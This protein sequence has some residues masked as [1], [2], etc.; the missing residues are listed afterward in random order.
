MPPQTDISDSQ[1]A[2]S[3]REETQN[4][5]I[6]VMAF[7]ILIIVFIVMFISDSAYLQTVMNHYVV[8]GLLIAYSLTKAITLPCYKYWYPIALLGGLFIGG[9]LISSLTISTARMGAILLA[10]VFIAD[11]LYTGW[12]YKN[13]NKMSSNMMYRYGTYGSVILAVIL[14]LVFG[15]V[16]I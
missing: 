11:A 12:S 6:L 10:V 3:L 9:W 8:L 13:D 5:S 16:A 14:A 2:K 4:S 15:Y 1:P 7:V